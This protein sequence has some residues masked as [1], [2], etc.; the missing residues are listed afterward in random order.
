MA[1][2]P[3]RYIRVFRE[4]LRS[5]PRS[6][7]ERLKACAVF[8]E[9]AALSERARRSEIAHVHAHFANHPATAAW[10]VHRL[11]DIP[12]SYTAHANDLFLLPPALREKLDE[13]AFIVTISRY[14]EQL[15]AE[16]KPR[17]PVFVVH[18][19]VDTT[20]LAELGRT[21]SSHR[22]LCV[23][24]LEERK[25]QRYLLEAVAELRDRFPDI[26]LVLI[27]DGPE[28]SSLEDFA[29][30]LA[31]GERMRF[32]GALPA[33]AVRDE[34]SHAAVFA[35]PS[36]I[37]KTGRTE[38]IPVALMEAMAAGVPVIS[39]R[40][41]GIPELVDGAGGLVEP[42]D[43]A[44]LANEIA[45]TFE[46]SRIRAARVSAARERV[47]AEFDLYREAAKLAD[48]IDGSLQRNGC[49]GGRTA[50]RA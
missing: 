40:V 39:T 2:D 35:L 19:G 46:D 36:I 49:A 26:E 44:G 5:T 10:I 38:G 7:Q 17:A 1:R 31:I 15:L 37:D 18:C 41:S 25:G 4:L 28:R 12:F 50:P 3:G 34:L 14:N 32:A 6:I 27:G 42:R 8:I 43:A 22:V 21:P 9:A 13:P 33:D 20:I 47:V 48:L 30:R 11:T 16:M 29:R 45:L 24:S 23:G